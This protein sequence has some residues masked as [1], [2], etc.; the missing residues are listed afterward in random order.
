MATASHRLEPGSWEPVRIC[1]GC[2][3]Y[4][5]SSQATLRQKKCYTIVRLGIRKGHCISQN[6]TLL[7]QTVL[8]RDEFPM[9]SY[10]HYSFCHSLR[11]FLH[12]YG[13]SRSHKSRKVR[14]SKHQYRRFPGKSL[15]AAA[16]QKGYSISSHSW[17]NFQ[18]T[19]G[20]VGQN[21]GQHYKD[22]QPMSTDNKLHLPKTSYFH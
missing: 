5:K 11:S 3:I 18:N 13:L 2:L 19:Y 6:R 1:T 22:L 10:C 15:S 21:M 16:A 17:I 20:H 7:V 9:A 8:G 4:R 14:V 12:S